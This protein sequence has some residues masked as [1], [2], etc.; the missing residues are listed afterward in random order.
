MWGR[1][2]GIF[3]Q[4]PCILFV[5]VYILHVWDTWLCQVN[6]QLFLLQ[7]C[8]VYIQILKKLLTYL[9]RTSITFTGRMGSWLFSINWVLNAL[10]RSSPSASLPNLYLG[11]PISR[12][13]Q[14]MLFLKE[15][16]KTSWQSMQV[17]RHWVIRN[18]SKRE[19]G[20][21][22]LT[23]KKHR[24]IA[25]TLLT[26]IFHS[27]YQLLFKELALFC[28][29]VSFLQEILCCL[30]NWCSQNMGFFR[31]PSLFI[32]GALVASVNQ[33]CYLKT[34]MEG[35]KQKTWGKK[36]KNMK[37]IRSL[38]IWQQCHVYFFLDSLS[39]IPALLPAPKVKL[40]NKCFSH[41]ETLPCFSI[42]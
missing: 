42:P 41:L 11:H 10:Q 32:R 23:L 40:T 6:T 17:E 27:R 28:N 5:A 2:P 21:F 29:F 9:R 18:N 30:F 37:Q 16:S 15:A 25:L 7:C 12:S 31:T 36:T 33:C 35:K 3:N 22:L 13:A 4:G 38:S 1:K 19:T 26:N 39:L 8:F 34:N 24:Y 20:T 14:F